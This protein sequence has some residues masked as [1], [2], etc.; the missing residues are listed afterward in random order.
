MN[1]LPK[2]FLITSKK[3][4]PEID[5]NQENK[6]SHLYIESDNILSTKKVPGL[7]IFSAR[8]SNQGTVIKLV[9]GKGVKLEKPIFLCFGILG[10]KGKQIILP[11]IILEARAE[12]KILA[13]CAFPQAESTFHQLKSKIKLEKESKLIYEEKHYHGEKFGATVLADFEISIGE[14]A[15]FKNEFILEEGSI[16]KLK[17]NLDA[18]IARDG[19]SEIFSKIIGKGKNDEA[20]IFDK[21][22]LQGENSKSLV[23]LVGAV[24]NGGKM[25]F[26]GETEAGKKAIN[27]RGHIDCQEIVIG[28][29][30]LAQ[31]VPIVKVNNPE[32]R[33]T[34]EASVGKVN[35]KE[36][37]TL[38]TRGLSEK[39]AIDFII[40]GKIR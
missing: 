15:D 7:K 13:H 28:K 25:F 31:S 20:E 1:Q 27:S 4:Y 34:H 19:V 24:K 14:K 3:Y 5:F 9:V 30:S 16:G 40:K 18:R 32:A 6:F 8:N 33:I 11:E 12:A 17:I 21:V 26:K 38:M 23:K 36:L 39:E 22:I 37:E 29:N 2:K 35:Q 10:Q